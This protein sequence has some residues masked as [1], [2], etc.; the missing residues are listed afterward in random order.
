MDSTQTIFIIINISHMY[1]YVD[2]CRGLC[3]QYS[4][5]G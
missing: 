1:V 3:D 4:A 5:A 2:I